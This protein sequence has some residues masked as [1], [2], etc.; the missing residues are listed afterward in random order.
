M[1]RVLIAELLCSDEDCAVT[2]EVVAESLEHL[3]AL[4]CEDC[5]C[6]LV[7]LS[8]SDVELVEVSRPIQ[9]RVVRELPRAA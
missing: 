9:M 6:T 7:T 8:I 4:L 2:V 5:G 3:D 1:A